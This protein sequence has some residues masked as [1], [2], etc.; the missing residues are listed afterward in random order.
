MDTSN[1][2][3]IELCNSRHPK[4]KALESNMKIQYAKLYEQDILIKTIMRENMKLK[5]RIY[6]DYD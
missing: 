3:Y 1:N 5:S 4:L 6:I 2:T